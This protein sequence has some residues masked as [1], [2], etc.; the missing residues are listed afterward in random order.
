MIKLFILLGKT[1]SCDFNDSVVLCGLMKRWFYLGPT[2]IGV[3]VN[4]A[5]VPPEIVLPSVG[6]RSSLWVVRCSW[7]THSL[8]PSVN[9]WGQGSWEWSKARSF[10]SIPQGPSGTE[11]VSTSATDSFSLILRNCTPICDFSWTSLDHFLSRRD[12]DFDL[13]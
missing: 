4:L 10:L 5:I 3:T 9:L 1:Q 12:G 11:T 13:L 8:Q 2:S 7:M 6:N